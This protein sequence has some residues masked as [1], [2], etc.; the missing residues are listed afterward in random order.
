MINYSLIFDSNL[1]EPNIKF[2][3]V[4]ANIINL[5][6]VDRVSDFLVYGDASLKSCSG[7]FK[8]NVNVEKFLLTK[9]FNLEKKATNPPLFI[10]LYS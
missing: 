8:E 10:P 2:Y 4:Q 3:H 9:C 6:I 5:F 7:V 1:T